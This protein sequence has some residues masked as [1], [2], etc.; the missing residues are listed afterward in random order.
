MY[1]EREELV[2]HIFPQLRSFCELRHVVLTEVDL[3]WGI[4]QEEIDAGKVLPICLAE[5]AN[6]Q[7]FF[8]CLLG[9]RYG[10]SVNSI[11]D[12]LVEGD[13]WLKDHEGKSITELEVWH[14]VLN[15]PP[16]LVHALFYF[17]SS[18]GVLTL[19]GTDGVA[20]EAEA[21]RKLEQLKRRILNS[22]AP[23]REYASPRQAGELLLADLKALFGQIFPEESIP[24]P[25]EQEAAAHDTFAESRSRIYIGLQQHFD[26]LDEHVAS[27][28]PPLI[29]TGEAGAGKSA[30][31]AS[32]ARRRMGYPT[33]IPLSSSL[34]DR[35]RGTIRRLVN[36]SPTREPDAFLLAHFVEASAG[37]ADWAAMLR[38]IMEALREHFGL[39][40][41]IPDRTHLLPLAF[42]NHLRAT[43]SLGTVI[44]LL[45]GIDHLMGGEQLSGLAWLPSDVPANVRLI[46][47]AA[48]GGVVEQLRARR[49]E[50]L[51]IKPLATDE[52]ATFITSY[53]EQ[54]RKR[55]DRASVRRV[56]LAAAAANPLYLRTVLEELRLFGRQSSELPAVIENLLAAGGTEELFE[57]VLVR[58]EGDYL[59]PP[60]RGGGGLAPRTM[61]LL[62]AAR[63][64]LSENELAEMLGTSDG[65]LPAALWSPFFLSVKESLLNRSGL[66][67]FSHEAFRRAAERRYLPAEGDRRDAHR[68]LAD[69]FARAGS[70]PRR[71]DELPWHLAALEEWGKLSSL[72]A[73]PEFL[74]VSWPAHQFEVKSYWSLVRSRSAF[75]M[76]DAYAQVLEDP[77]RYMECAWAVCTLLA[78]AGHAPEAL[79]LSEY[80]EQDA[81]AS[82]DAAA[83]QVSLSMRAV[84]LRRRGAAD[85]ALELLREQEQISRR[86][87]QWSAVAASLGNQAVILRER[88]ESVAALALHRQEE[89]I[90]RRLQDLAGISACLGNQAVI[91]QVEDRPG[92]LKLLREQE[93]I[94]RLLGDI[95][96]LQ[97]SL[98]NQG[99]ILWRGGE[100]VAALKLLKADEELCRRLGDPASLHLCLGNQAVILSALGD[101]DGAV[102]M[103]HEKERICR[104]T[105]DAAG[106]VRAL[107][108]QAQLY[109]E[110]L[111]QPIFA[112]PLAEEAVQIAEQNGL[113]QMTREVGQ[114]V[115]AL[116][117][118]AARL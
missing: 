100:S 18:S 16:D 108:Y 44:L 88:G 7:P 45:D 105:N 91:I 106:L 116:R 81:R 23:V 109:A 80:L 24:G 51:K 82:G 52:R 21:G 40:L 118:R 43:A 54:Y 107:H 27:R 84:L 47:T 25:L 92:A 31:L 74:R 2:K 62:W 46:V 38:R 42:A 56:T 57:K 15:R 102:E 29:V 3:R 96:G 66:L 70:W 10:T 41:D 11:P 26:Y 59:L 117:S 39:S 30:L 34:S 36:P 73:S 114:L 6:C 12:E 90:C 61:R 101:Y 99:L 75:Q 35:L 64:G 71:V 28:R 104:E 89:E 110:K 50:V 87:E 78:D 33:S 94:C 95:T 63:Q 98:G 22:H 8:V 55:L 60:A 14:G 5:V 53:L 77:E 20:E 72:L 65:P 68:E 17:R 32:W 48:D 113:A 37:S 97:K 86:S 112:L 76:T 1:A 4:P 85:A 19:P 49:W 111:R 103:Y 13:P 69:Y 115:D 9:D 58:L 93:A 67:S 83:L 79:A